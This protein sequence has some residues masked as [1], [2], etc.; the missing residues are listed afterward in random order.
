MTVFIFLLDMEMLKYN[1]LRANFSKR[2][3]IADDCKVSFHYSSG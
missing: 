2:W 1:I 3:L